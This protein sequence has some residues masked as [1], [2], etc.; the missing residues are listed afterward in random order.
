MITAKEK[1]LKALHEKRKRYKNACLSTP[2][3][4]SEFWQ[5]CMMIVDDLI[6]DLKEKDEKHGDLK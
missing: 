1:V 3:K 6:E 4:T 5:E 2:G